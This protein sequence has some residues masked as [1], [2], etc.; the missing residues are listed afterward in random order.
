MSWTSGA[1][2]D[3]GVF[4]GAIMP[5]SAADPIWTDVQ[6][7]D[8]DL[9]NVQGRWS[10]DSL[11]LLPSGGSYTQTWKPLLY[12]AV[13]N[14][15]GDT[16]GYIGM[17]YK[18]YLNQ[19]NEWVGEFSYRI[20]DAN[21]ADVVQLR[22]WMVGGFNPNYRDGIYFTFGVTHKNDHYYYWFA[23]ADVRINNNV[24]TT[25]ANGRWVR[26]DF[27]QLAALGTPD[28]KKIKESPE[29]GPAALPDGGYNEDAEKKGTFDTHSDVIAPSPAPTLSPLISNFFHAYVV[30][31]ASMQYLADAM[32]PDLDWSSTDL[33]TILGEVGQAI[34]YNKQIDYMLD[35]LILPIDVPHGNWEHIKVGGKELKTVIGGTDIYI[36]G[37]PASSCYVTVDCGTLSIDGFW[38]SWLDFA[39]TRVKLFLPYVGFVDVQ[40]EYI[41]DGTLHVQYRFNIVDGSFIVFL[42]ASSGCSEL[43]DSLI[44]QYAGVAAM[45]VPLQSLDYSTKISGLISAIGTVAAGAASGGIGAAAAAGA[46]ANVANT[47]VQKPGS[48]HANGYNASSSFLSHRQPYL[49]IERQTSQFSECYPQEVGLPLNAMFTL[50]ALHGLTICKNPK[51]NFDC[52]EEEAKAIKKALQEGVIL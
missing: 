10:G 5:V 8:F 48:T 26:E 34:F 49:I 52:T 44:G 33:V 28:I 1:R 2:A 3:Y 24:V 36:N 31:E 29:F 18:S 27:A 12:F 35:L 22:N 7:Q 46:G 47:M 16:T 50:S 4:A 20:L 42:M 40:P 32:F 39:G 11:Y 13:K 41:I 30:T 9:N 25:N 19:R 14:S 51:L 38:A 21:K 23:S 37:Q 17:H 6:S 15:S 45:H 43:A